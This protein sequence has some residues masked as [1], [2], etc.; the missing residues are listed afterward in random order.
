MDCAG[1]SAAIR[2]VARMSEAAMPPGGTMKSA[3]LT[4][5]PL[6]VV[7]RI[8]PE[9][10]A[11]GTAKVSA[12][13]VTDVVAAAF[14]L[15]LTAV[16]PPAALKFAPLTVTTVPAAP[17][18]GVKFVIVGA[19]GAV[20][21]KSDALATVL[22]ATVTVTFPVVAPAGTVTE[23]DAA[24][25]ALTA[26]ATPLN[27]TVFCAAFALKPVPVM[28]TNVPADPLGGAKCDSVICAE[29]TRWIPTMLPTASYV[30]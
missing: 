12:V 14:W 13:G 24:V 5:L 22:P 29:L 3:A 15:S 23:S 10:V 26:A 19:P 25:A 7:T 28:V 11:A 30:Y 6:A 9:P 20:T 8:F 27:E 16:A 18:V 2:T 17:E 1:P 21:T 4:T